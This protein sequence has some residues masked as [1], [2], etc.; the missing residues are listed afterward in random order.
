MIINYNKKYYKYKQKYLNLKGGFYVNPIPNKVPAE[1]EKYI[2][3]MANPELKLK[4]S[5]L[6]NV[7]NVNNSE[8]IFNKPNRTQKI[9][10]KSYTI[11]T[12]DEE[13]LIPDITEVIGILDEMRSRKSRILKNIETIDFGLPFSH[14][15]VLVDGYR[16]DKRS[17]DEQKKIIEL[18]KNLGTYFPN[19]KKLIFGRGYIDSLND[20]L[21]LFTQL[22]NL[23]LSD[24]YNKELGTSLD[25]LEELTNL[26]FGG[27]FNQPLGTSLNKLKKLEYLTFGNQFNQ[28]LGTSLN[29]LTK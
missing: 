25:K 16:Y 6:K 29:E 28:P 21:G 24:D 17:P 4:I 3:E 27:Q 20:S 12:I 5:Q 18:L 11:L 2:L 26:T 23:I 9:D 19:V 1:L 8:I 7:L 14:T 10:V 13:I 15:G 22:T